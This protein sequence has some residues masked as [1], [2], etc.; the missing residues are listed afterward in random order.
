M[1]EYEKFVDKKKYSTIEV[2]VKFVKIIQECGMVKLQ[3]K[4][5]SHRVDI[6]EDMGNQ[7][8]NMICDI[9]GDSF[10]RACVYDTL[11]SYKK[12]SLFQG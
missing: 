4:T 6:D 9:G 1:Q 5:A 3:K 2:M 8:E 10:R 12:E 11:N 7:L